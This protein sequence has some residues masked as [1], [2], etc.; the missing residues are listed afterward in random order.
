MNREQARDRG[1]NSVSEQITLLKMTFQTNSKFQQE[2]IMKGKCH[3]K[4]MNPVLI[5]THLAK[6]FKFVLKK[7]SLKRKS[8]FS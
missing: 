2:G 5:V 6:I 4:R 3:S 7:P 8:E 1:K